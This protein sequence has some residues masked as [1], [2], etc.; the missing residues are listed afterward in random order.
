MLSSL[1]TPSA[2]DDEPMDETR[3]LRERRE[4]PSTMLP[5]F[6]RARRI[7]D[8]GSHEPPGEPIDI[9]GDP[10]RYFDRGLIARGGMAEVR[11]V[12]DY[13]L[14]RTL[15]MKILD[16]DYLEERD[17]RAL[18]IVEASVTAGLQHPGIVPVHDWG[19]L[20]DGRLWFTMKE[21]RGRTLAELIEDFHAV[22]HGPDWRAT[23]DGWTLHRL[24]DTLR[25][26]CEAVAYAHRHGV[27][28][29]DIKPLNLMVGEL[30]EVQVMDWG[31]SARLGTDPGFELSGTPAFMSPEQAAGEALGPQTDVY[32]L[33]AV[34]GCILVGKPPY[35]GGMDEVLTAIALGPPPPLSESYAPDRPI[36][37]TALVAVFE[38]ATAREVAE[39]Y[40]DAAELAEEL[41]AWLEGA[42]RRETALKVL[43]AA[44]ALY[45]QIDQHNR[46]AAESLSRAAA[47]LRD[48]G[49]RAP[50]RSKAEA[51]TL[52]ERAVRLEHDAHVIEVQWLQRVRSALNLDET[53]SEAH[54]RLA[55]H[56]HT[57]LLTAEAEGRSNDAARNEAFL[58]AHDRGRYAAVLR[59]DGALT[60]QTDP[61]GATVMAYRYVAHERRLVLERFGA[62]G[63]TPLD[64]V[65][66][67]RG[68]YLLLVRSP[69]KATVRLPVLIERAGH[70][71]GAPPGAMEPLPLVLRSR[72]A[73]PRGFVRVPAGWFRCGGDPEACEPL[74]AKRI[75]VDDFLIGRY[76]VTNGQYVQFLNMLVDAGRAEEAERFAPRAPLGVVTPESAAPVQLGR[77]GAGHFHLT[78]DYF[79]RQWHPDW[80]VCLIDWHAASA[81]A[82]WQAEKLGMGVRLPNELEWE[83]AARGADSRGLPWGSYADPSWS[84]VL[85]NGADPGP[86]PLHSFR[87]DASPYGVRHMA[88]NVREWCVNTWRAEGPLVIEDVLQPDIAGDD[89][90][91]WR[92]A[93]GGSWHAVPAHGR[94]AG[95]FVAEPSCRFGSL[96]FRLVVV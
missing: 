29:R 49:P 68:S 82:R 51:W 36:P 45:P 25:R 66:L 79:G 71:D 14:R 9:V 31:L 50:A 88:G 8:R 63:T 93:R 44:D 5:S 16:R 90:L 65:A 7:D 2:T 64:R 20:G 22:Q 81:Y 35:P 26:A 23:D 30:A 67:P 61:P 4:Y 87:I 40:H 15:A 43:A 42:S 89:D 32:S 28:H 21:V 55:S 46:E 76:P 39:R 13:K 27:I 74:P 84:N 48:L 80:P 92:A 77:D 19:E 94:A 83:K 78:R 52:E 6:A 38:R 18:F 62:L 47:M 54:E 17:G 91:T 75:W 59:G 95:R 85:G 53:L 72:R 41:G 12:F 69:R 86:T 24:I 11:R 57:R 56:Y 10:D 34:L 58:R 3:K 73:V 70:W 96:G 33:G 60:L 37:P 1:F